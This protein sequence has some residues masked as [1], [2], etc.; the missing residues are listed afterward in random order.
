MLDQEETRSL[1]ITAILI[2][3]FGILGCILT[4]QM[5]SGI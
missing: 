5:I 2:I 4:A 1:A 3:I